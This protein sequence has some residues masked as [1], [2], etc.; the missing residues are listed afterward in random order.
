M[1]SETFIRHFDLAEEKLA[2][3]ELIRVSDASPSADWVTRTPS[4]ATTTDSP[5]T[6]R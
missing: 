6:A 5:A 1:A 3:A 4:R 2:A